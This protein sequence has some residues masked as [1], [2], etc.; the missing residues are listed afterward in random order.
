MIG[1]YSIVTKNVEPYT[2]V[3]GNLAKQIRKRYNDDVVAKL[4]D[5]GWWD[6]TAEKI[7]QNVK[8]LTGNDLALLEQCR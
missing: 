2:I 1:S 3:G 4:L 5:I 8:L 7:A 6:R